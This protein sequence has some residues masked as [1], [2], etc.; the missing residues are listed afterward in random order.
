MEAP[1]WAHCL[2]GGRRV[3][4]LNACRKGMQ[5]TLLRHITLREFFFQLEYDT[6]RPLSYPGT[7]RQDCN[8]TRILFEFRFIFA[9][10]SHHISGRLSHL[11]LNRLTDQ[12]WKCQ[13][14]LDKW[15]TGCPKKTHFQN[16]HPTSSSLGE[17]I[18]KTSW[19]WSPT[20]ILNVQNFGRVFL[21][22]NFWYQRNLRCYWQSQM[23]HRKIR[24]T[25]ASEVFHKKYYALPK[26]LRFLRALWYSY[27]MSHMYFDISKHRKR[28]W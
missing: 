21:R 12:L 4:M 13:D 1:L 19:T 2:F 26:H 3:Q 27:W 24:I 22:S 16:H 17:I 7:L 14:K 20:L 9:I 18:F 6:L 25:L 10:Y 15:G 28:K 23:L 8:A 5:E 11:F